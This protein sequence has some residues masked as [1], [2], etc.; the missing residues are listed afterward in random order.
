MVSAGILSPLCVLYDRTM[1]TREYIQERY[2]LGPMQDDPA[3]VQLWKRYLG[4]EKSAFGLLYQ[5]YHQRLT[6]FCLGILKEESLAEDIAS[7]TLNKLL[8]Y[9]NPADIRNAEQWLFTVAKNAC[10]S[11]MQQSKRR[12]EAETD[13]SLRIVTVQESGAQ[14][15]MLREDMDQVIE[16][17]LS[18]KERMVWKLHQ[19]GYDNE[20]IASKTGMSI[21]TVANHKAIARKKLREVLRLFRE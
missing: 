12:K 17:T 2:Y 16:N 19:A 21:K 5:N 13:I 11:A 8:Q 3:H 7:E 20:E 4:G 10:F 14:G 1:Y 15:K 18:E 9:A 6:F